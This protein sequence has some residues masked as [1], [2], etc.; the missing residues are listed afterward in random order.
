MY[1]ESAYGLSKSKHL[2]YFTT[3]LTFQFMRHITHYIT[4]TLMTLSLSCA[5]YKYQQLQA[6]N[7]L[8]FKKVFWDYPTLAYSYIKADAPKE[9]RNKI[10]STFYNTIK[11]ELSIIPQDSFYVLTSQLRNNDSAAISLLRVFDT[12]RDHGVD[13]LIFPEYHNLFNRT[14]KGKGGLKIKIGSGLKM[15]PTRIEV[16]DS[17]SFFLAVTMIYYHA[18]NFS[19]VKVFKTELPNSYTGRRNK[20]LPGEPDSFR[21]FELEAIHIMTT[22]IRNKIKKYIETIDIQ[23]NVNK[24]I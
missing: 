22:E 7:S 21:A 11:E 20:Y 9:I 15:K 6:A 2:H 4:L 3:T 8:R 17:T 24:P 23:R 14:M 1:T 18:E 13:F 5:G 10:D 19:T 16:V 12:L